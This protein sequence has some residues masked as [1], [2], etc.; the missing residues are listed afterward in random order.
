[1]PPLAVD[2]RSRNAPLTDSFQSLA[3]RKLSQ[4]TRLHPRMQH[5]RVVTRA[6]RG[7]FIVEAQIEGDGLVARAEERA[8]TLD[9]ALDTVVD[10]LERQLGRHR[11]R[12]AI[13]GRP[14]TSATPVDDVEE[15]EDAGTITRR[16]K[17]SLKPVSAEEAAEQMEL[18]GHGF[19]VFHNSQTGQV[20][21]VYRRWDGNYGLLEP[22]S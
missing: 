20:N 1:M 7:Q 19:F 16:K 8:D 13:R 18:L 12:Q 2:F 21:V 15:T 6:E 5:A 17:F 9:T 3:E 11:E 14:N 4:L 22:E 10:R